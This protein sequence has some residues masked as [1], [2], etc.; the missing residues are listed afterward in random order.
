MSEVY[1][2][3]LAVGV[4]LA[5]SSMVFGV[6]LRPLRAI[7]AM[8]CSGSTGTHFWLA[9]T[10]V[11]L[12]IAP[13]LVTLIGFDPGGQAATLEVVRRAAIGA[14]TAAMAALLVMGL[15]ISQSRPRPSA[16]AP[17][18]SPNPNEFWG[19]RAAR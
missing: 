1:G 11:T 9:F 16:T 8:I 18:T 13:L 14:L 19:D 15:R 12:Y 5:I 2:F 10:G 4:S 17:A 7:L 3:V 6:M